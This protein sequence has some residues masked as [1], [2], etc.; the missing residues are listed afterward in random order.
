VTFSNISIRWIPMSFGCWIPLK[1]EKKSET[2]STNP[3]C[4]EFVR[5]G[6][7]SSWDWKWRFIGCE[8]PHWIQIVWNWLSEKPPISTQWNI[9]STICHGIYRKMDCFHSNLPS[10]RSPYKCRLSGADGIT[11]NHCSKCSWDGV[12]TFSGYYSPRSQNW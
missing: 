4:F 8:T 5:Y 3:D 2:F 12:C 9:H 10:I 11:K 1:K 6:M 7:D